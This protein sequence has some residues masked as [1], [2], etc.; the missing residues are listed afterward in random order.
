MLSDELLGFLIAEFQKKQL[1]PE[2][3]QLRDP[4]EYIYLSFEIALFYSFLFIIPLNFL[5]L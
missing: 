3:V 2:K 5:Y 1:S 4:Q